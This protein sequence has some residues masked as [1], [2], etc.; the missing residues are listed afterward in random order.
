MLSCEVDVFQRLEYIYYKLGL[1][2]PI[3]CFQNVKSSS[4]L[5]HRAVLSDRS[6]SVSHVRIE[7]NKRYFRIWVWKTF[8]ELKKYLKIAKRSTVRGLLS[9]NE[10]IEAYLFDD[11]IVDVDKYL[12]LFSQRFLS[13]LPKRSKDTILRKHQ[14]SRTLY[15]RI[16]LAVSSFINRFSF[17]RR[18]SIVTQLSIHHA[19]RLIHVMICQKR[20]LLHLFL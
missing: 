11:A 18:L 20:S 8:M 15:R 5:L 1:N 3:R 16:S 2:N 13:I 10:V 9:V 4:S 17:R 14:R 6:R 12:R 7:E 19:A